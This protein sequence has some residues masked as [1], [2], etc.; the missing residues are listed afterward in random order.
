MK[1]KIKDSRWK[2]LETKPKEEKKLTQRQKNK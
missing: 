1:G 2:R